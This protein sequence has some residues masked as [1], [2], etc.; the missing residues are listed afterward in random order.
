MRLL[1][2][3]FVVAVLTFIVGVTITTIYLIRNNAST[4]ERPL[5]ATANPKC[6]PG[7]SIKLDAAGSEQISY[8]PPGVFSDNE[9]QNQFTVNWYS[10][11]LM[12][13][14]EP[15]L[16]S[17]QNYTGES[18]RFLWLRTFDNP[19]AIRL[20]RSSDQ[21]FITVKQLDGKGGY[22]PGKLIINKT[23]TV[24]EREWGIFNDHLEQSCYWDLPRVGGEGGQ[25]GA[26]WIVEGSREGRYHIVDHWSPKSGSYRELCLY[27]LKL[28]EIQID[29][30]Y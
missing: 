27:L 25:D 23:R 24:D 19:I 14:D 11:H 3:R 9:W 12:A 15:S 20:W 8:F 16:F 17:L 30:I 2:I 29:K 6:F 10:K 4:V 18:Y 13:M 22:E 21:R 26:Q 7:Q 5:Q 1:T 28:A